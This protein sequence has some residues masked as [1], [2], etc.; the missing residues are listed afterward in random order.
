MTIEQ[1]ER[2]CLSKR[3]AVL[4]FPFG[5]DPVYKVGGKIFALI[6]RDVP[7]KIVV[8]CDPRLVPILREVYPAVTSAPYLHKSHWNQVVL[9]D[10][11]PD[12][13]L[14]DMIDQSYFLVVRGL[15]A[16][17]RNRLT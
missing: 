9:D 7:S 13:E 2:H 17:V 14:L 10:S 4:D 12:D 6:R 1:V 8:K 11:I 5:E 16:A 15:P 3:E